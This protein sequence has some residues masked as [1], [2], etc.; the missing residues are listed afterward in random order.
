M[1]SPLLSQAE[2]KGRFDYD[3]ETGIFTDK[4]TG[5]HAGKTDAHGYL[6]VSIGGKSVPLHRLAFM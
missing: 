1:S 2:V 6:R 4:T 3:P 5:L